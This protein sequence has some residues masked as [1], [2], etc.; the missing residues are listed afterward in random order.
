MLDQEDDEEAGLLD[1]EDDEAGL[2]DQEEDAGLLDQE[3]L[4]EAGWLEDDNESLGEDPLPLG[5]SSPSP[6]VPPIRFFGAAQLLGVGKAEASLEV[7]VALLDSG[8][9]L[10][11]AGA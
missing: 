7:G 8:T 3:L 10:L 6:H 2:L 4:D 5:S 1:H 11:Y 9:Q